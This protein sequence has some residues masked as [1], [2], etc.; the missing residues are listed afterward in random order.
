MI[1]KVKKIEKT[2]HVENNGKIKKWILRR[3]RMVR[4][5]DKNLSDKKKSYNSTCFYKFT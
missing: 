1:V 5:H 3:Q 2:R 4:Y